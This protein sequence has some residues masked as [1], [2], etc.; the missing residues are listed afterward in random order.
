VLF[1]P[2]LLYLSFL[3]ELKQN[4]EAYQT[5]YDANELKKIHAALLATNL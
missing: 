5:F 1:K 4:D 3:E 2:L